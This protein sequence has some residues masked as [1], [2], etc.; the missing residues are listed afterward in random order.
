MKAGGVIGHSASCSTN[1]SSASRMPT[2]GDR[3]ST[4]VT[5]ASPSAQAAQ[6]TSASPWISA[7]GSEPR[8]ASTTAPSAGRGYVVHGAS[9]RPTV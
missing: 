4:A 6:A 2:H 8:P 1:G 9:R 5:P 7:N 3:A